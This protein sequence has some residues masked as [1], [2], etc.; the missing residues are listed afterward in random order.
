MMAKKIAVV[1]LTWNGVSWLQKFLPTVVKHSQEADIFVIDNASTDGTL[2]FLTQHFPEVKIISNAKNI[3]FAAGYNEGLKS[4]PN[5]FY[6]LLNSD[7]EVTENWLQSP[8]EIFE[9]N[10]EIWDKNNLI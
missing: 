5:E 10:K 1:I 8:L 7:V 6:C 4:V 9:K 3:G 2:A